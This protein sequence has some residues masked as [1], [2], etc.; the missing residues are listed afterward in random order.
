MA[1]GIRAR[2]PL[3]RCTVIGSDRESYF[4]DTTIAVDAGAEK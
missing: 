3:M 2:E 1:S 4:S